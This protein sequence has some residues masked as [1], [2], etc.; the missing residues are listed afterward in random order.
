MNFSQ[1]A[2]DFTRLARMFKPAARHT[3]PETSHVAAQDASVRACK[4]RML[5]LLWL[6]KCVSLTDFELAIA[7]N[8]QQT[9]I[10]KRRG[11]CVAAGWVEAN[12]DQHGNKVKRP[13]PSG[14]MALTWR[15][16]SLGR[17]V[18]RQTQPGINLHEKD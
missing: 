10:G 17:H 5:V 14:S 12:T 3:D 9:S 13:T 8:V 2:L 16:T 18:C 1:I 4:S 15:I 7:T 6:C 11:E